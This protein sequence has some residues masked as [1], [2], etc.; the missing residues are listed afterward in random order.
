MLM[1]ACGRANH[2]GNSRKPPSFKYDYYFMERHQRGTVSK[3]A[4]M[5]H[6]CRHRPLHDVF[7]PFG[8]SF[9]SSSDTSVLAM[10]A[11]CNDKCFQIFIH[12]PILLWAIIWTYIVKITLK[13]NQPHKKRTW[14]FTA[15]RHK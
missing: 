6:P 4:F 8:D 9:A 12:T 5:L 1:C 13:K 15:I 14:N 7:L 3:R 10:S 2:N 11:S